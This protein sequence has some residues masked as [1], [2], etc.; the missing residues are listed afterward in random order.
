MK[1]VVYII[2]CKNDNRVYIGSS[3]NYKKRFIEHRNALLN[4]NHHCIHLQRYINKYG[5]DEIYFEVLEFCDN[6][7]EREQY[8]LDNIIEK[9]NTSKSAHSPMLGRSQ[10]K[11]CIKKMSE[12]MILNNPVPKGSKRPKYIVD[13]LIKAN[14]GRKISEKERLNRKLSILNKKSVTLIDFEKNISYNF[15]SIADCARYIGISQQSVSAHL[16]GVKNIRKSLN[17][18]YTKT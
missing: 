12:R 15:I 13:I 1:G 5:I 11:E 18:V 3:I 10:S 8:Y 17:I 9:F 14:R 4:K 7:L 16:R 2:K 6:Y